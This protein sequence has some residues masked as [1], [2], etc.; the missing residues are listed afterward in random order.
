MAGQCHVLVYVARHPTTDENEQNVFRGADDPPLNK[1]GFKEAHT[2]ASYFEPIELSYVFT[3]DKTRTKQ[4]AK[5]ICDRKEGCDPIANP[6]L[7]PWDTGV[8][9]GKPKS[10]ENIDKLQYYV[11]NPDVSI[12]G[13]AS[14]NEFKD[15]IQPLLA[16]A[17]DMAMHVG[18]PLLLVVHSSVVH[19]VG[20]MF[21]ENHESG[22]IRPGGVAAV[23]I[24]DGKINVEP[25]FK[26]DER[27]STQN[28]LGTV[29]R[30]RSGLTS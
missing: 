27:S 18:V 10:K 25:I 9:G 8:F 19:E 5:I 4:T 23:Y 12:P 28:V 2:L 6:N 24:K 16:D 20:E 15:R 30:H 26:P 3:S 14:L 7:N 13:G 22:H 1:K 21:G 17:V 11:R 29:G